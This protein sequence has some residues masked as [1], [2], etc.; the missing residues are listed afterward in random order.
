MFDK[1]FAV[2]KKYRHGAVLDSEDEPIVD[3][4][5]RLG[6]MRIGFHDKSEDNEQ[7]L[8]Q[9]AGLTDY[10]KLYFWKESIDRNPIKRWFHNL[11][12]SV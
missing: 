5:A 3:E 6:Y 4:L 10:G 12:H 1:E 7:D 11:I 9:T 8:E 2:L